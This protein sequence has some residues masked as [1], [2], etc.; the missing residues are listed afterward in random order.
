MIT[1]AFFGKMPLAS[2]SQKKAEV[3]TISG[4]PPHLLPEINVNKRC[5]V[6]KRRGMPSSKSLKLYI[7]EV[8][9]LKVEQ[10]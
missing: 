2:R 6:L 1:S 3:R 9:K 10:R 5:K 8:C 7:F 4:L